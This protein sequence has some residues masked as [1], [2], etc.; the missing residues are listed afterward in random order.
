[1]KKFAIRKIS[2]STFTLDKI[3]LKPGILEFNIPVRTCVITFCT[4]VVI[5]R[6]FS[7]AERRFLWEAYNDNISLGSR[8]DEAQK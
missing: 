2:M 4:R 6:V 1:M 7:F 3:Q 8:P 5:S